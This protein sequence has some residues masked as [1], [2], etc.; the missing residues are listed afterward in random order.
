MSIDQSDIKN[1]LFFT[2]NKYGLNQ[3]FIKDLFNLIKI[4]DIVLIDCL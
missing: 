2:V 1:I 4:C 3:I